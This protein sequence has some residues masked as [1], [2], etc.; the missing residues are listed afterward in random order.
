R[1]CV[2]V[3]VTIMRDI[4][5]YPDC[6]TYLCQHCGESFSR[7]ARGGR[8]RV[9]MAAMS[10]SRPRQRRPIY[11]RLQSRDDDIR[12]LRWMLKTLLRKLGLRCLS[13]EKEGRP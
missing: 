4:R 7:A 9:E 6:R 11:M 2:R 3:D 12:R 1:P 13:V 8:C 10:T 5:H